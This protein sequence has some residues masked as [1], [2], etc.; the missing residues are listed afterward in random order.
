MRDDSACHHKPSSHL[1]PIKL[2]SMSSSQLT[3]QTQENQPQADDDYVIVDVTPPYPP[4]DPN[5]PL[6]PAPPPVISVILAI[7]DTGSTRC[8]ADDSGYMGVASDQR[9]IHGIP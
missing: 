2:Q 8:T 3:V 7:Y 4:H 5:G 6:I 1:V 9:W